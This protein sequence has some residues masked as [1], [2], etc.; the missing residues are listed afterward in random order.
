MQKCFWKKVGHWPT[1]GTRFDA[2]VVEL[3]SDTID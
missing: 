2:D 1:I 3:Q